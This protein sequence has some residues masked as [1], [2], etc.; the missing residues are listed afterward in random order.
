MWGRGSR[1]DW[2]FIEGA[3]TELRKRAE[4]RFAV[5]V[6][7]VDTNQRGFMRDLSQ[8]STEAAELLARQE[9]HPGWPAKLTPDHWQVID[10]VRA[11]YHPTVANGA[12][13]SLARICDDLD[14]TK[15]EFSRLFP[16][17]LNSVLRISG[18]PGPRRS[19]NGS[20]LSAGQR[21]RAGDWWARL[22]A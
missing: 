16:G 10:Y 7:V 18:M 11:H 20:Q 13:P 5:A 8:W 21:L 14:L 15:N 1:A 3:D 17:G 9:G 19:A 4:H 6:T 22:T 2:F 12:K